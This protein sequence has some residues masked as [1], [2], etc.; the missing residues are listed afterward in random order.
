VRPAGCDLNGHVSGEADQSPYVSV[1]P[2]WIINR[3]RMHEAVAR[4]QA[5]QPVAWA[6]L[7]QELGYFDQAHFIAD[8]RR[9]IGRTPAD[10][11][12]T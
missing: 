12:H 9:L 6:A 10:Y 8:F 5:S 3:Y 11:A 4:A 7:A 2:K 1:G